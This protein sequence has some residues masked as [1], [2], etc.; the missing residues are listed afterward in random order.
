MSVCQT[1]ERHPR[2][3]I[4]AMTYEYVAHS[5]ADI[6]GQPSVF[7][8]TTLVIYC[9]YILTFICYS[10]IVYDVIWANAPWCVA[11]LADRMG[12]LS[13]KPQ[14]SPHTLDTR[15]DRNFSK[16]AH[17]GNCSS[18]G[19]QNA[20]VDYIRLSLSA[21]P[22]MSWRLITMRADV[23]A[24]GKARLPFLFLV[25]DWEQ[26]KCRR[27]SLC[28]WAAQNASWAKKSNS[29][30]PLSLSISIDRRQHKS[31]SLQAKWTV[32]LVNNQCVKHQVLSL[33][34]RYYFTRTRSI[35]KTLPFQN[36]LSLIQ[37]ARAQC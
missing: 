14:A 13:H 15:L 1:I 22:S 26:K 23:A 19:T 11:L 30:V 24:K 25:L 28:G 8:S 31:T 6:T 2:R 18:F 3:I 16:L 29:S 37:L 21:K 35:A 7:R 9:L 17:W 32:A 33:K 5:D 10:Y 34:T 36:S 20:E 27:R 12:F 4:Q